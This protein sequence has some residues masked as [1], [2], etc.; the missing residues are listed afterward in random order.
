[1]KSTFLNCSRLAVFFCLA[2]GSSFSVNT[3]ASAQQG[4]IER[5]AKLDALVSQQS[6]ALTALQSKLAKLESQPRVL[7]AGRI[8]VPV[9]NENY[10]RLAVPLPKDLGFDPAKDHIVLTPEISTP[11][12]HNYL[13]LIDDVKKEGFTIHVADVQSTKFPREDVPVHWA[14]IRQP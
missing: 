4:L 12:K 1:M 6:A 10:G 2:I 9:N 14:I 8:V 3:S 11:G 5:L 13:P 7:L